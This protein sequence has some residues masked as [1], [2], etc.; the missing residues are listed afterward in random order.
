MIIRP[1]L[2]IFRSGTILKLWEKQVRRTKG[3]HLVTTETRFVW[4]KQGRWT[5]FGH[6]PMAWQ[7]QQLAFVE[8][9]ESP[10]SQPLRLLIKT[11]FGRIFHYLHQT[12]RSL[13]FCPGFRQQG[14]CELFC[15]FALKELSTHV[16]GFV[17]ALGDSNTVDWAKIG[18]CKLVGDEGNHLVERKFPEGLNVHISALVTALM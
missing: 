14:C 13:S 11:T 6:L 5:T 12:S 4:N 15:G 18:V 3:A 1:V 16:A 8:G 7:E 17:P 10:R 2:S 9:W